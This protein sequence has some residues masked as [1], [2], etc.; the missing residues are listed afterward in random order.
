[1]NYLVTSAADGARVLRARSVQV[2]VAGTTGELQFACP[3]EFVDCVRTA[4]AE[5]AA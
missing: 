5:S 3:A 1:V 2:A 4:M